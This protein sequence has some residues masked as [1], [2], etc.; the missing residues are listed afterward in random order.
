MNEYE[1]RVEVG[2]EGW[3]SCGQRCTFGRKEQFGGGLQWQLRAGN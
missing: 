2:G 3:L 1:D